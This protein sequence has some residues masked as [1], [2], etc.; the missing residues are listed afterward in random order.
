M[1]KQNNANTVFVRLGCAKATKPTLR[2]WLWSIAVILCFLAQVIF[3]VLAGEQ[4]GSFGG[5]SN[6]QL[7][8]EQPSFLTPDGL[9]FSVWTIIYM[10]QGIFSIYQV[11]PCVQNSHAGIARARF[12]VVLLFL[13]NCLWLPVFS[14]RLY[15]LALMLILAMDLSLVMIYRTMMINY[16]A[17]DRTQD[18]SMLLPSIVL[19]DREHTRSRLGAS[20]EF[21]GRLLHP[22]PVKLL[23]FT[24]FSANSSWLSVATV[25]NLLVATGSSGWH[26]PYTVLT[27]SSFN[28]TNLVPTTIYVNGNVDFVIMAVCLVAALACVMAV[29][30]CDI[31]YALVAIWALGGV[32]RAQGS[33]APS[34]FPDAAMSKPIADWASAMMVVV[35]IA[36]AIGLIRAIVETVHA[37]I[38]AAVAAEKRGVDASS[39]LDAKMHYTDE[40]KPLPTGN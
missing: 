5:A 38:A 28:A 16:G 15:W 9:T 19:E 17:L 3:N 11:I 21:P 27:P 34:G 1:E 7:S 29:R 22:W 2:S 37:H 20:E 39:S 8:Q 24:G 35:A 13:G 40:Q 33:K 30:N 12:W 10:F 23:C 14:N 4:F 18:A 6:S 26:Q 32:N 25:V 36:A 31:P